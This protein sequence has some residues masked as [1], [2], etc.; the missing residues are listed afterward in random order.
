MADE[1]R[2]YVETCCFIDLV[3]VK[4]GKPTEADRETDVW[5]LKRLLEANRDGEVHLFTSTLT[6]AECRHVGDNDISEEVKSQFNRLLMSGQYVRLVQMTPFIASDA[7][8]L[9]WVHGITG[10][11]GADAIH[12]A[13]AIDRKCE[14]FLTA[15]GRL[16][17]LG[18]QA[19]PL[20]RF[21]LYARR[22]KD[23]ICL[24]TKYRQMKFEDEETS[25]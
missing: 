6:I 3:K 2:V 19:G 21:G 22:G 8:D 13:S 16:E 17:R 4:L 18:K 24:P 7:R 15:N 10:I 9:H 25:H 14:E 11:R 23:T 12:I 5:F 20:A 1:R